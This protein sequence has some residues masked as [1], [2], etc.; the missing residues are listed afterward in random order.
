MMTLKNSLLVAGTLL[1][2]GCSPRATTINFPVIPPELADCKFFSLYE[3]ELGANI[4]VAR[5]PNSTTSTT[6]N[7]GKKSKTTVVIDGVEYEATPK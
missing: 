5:C 3:G 2:I 4:T 7:S 6:Y 1:L